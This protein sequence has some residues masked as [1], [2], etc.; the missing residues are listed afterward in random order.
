[1]GKTEKSS[2]IKSWCGY[3]VQ[4]SLVAQL[5]P[6][7]CNP[8]DCSMSD[9]PVQHQLPELAQIHVCW[10]GEATNHLILCQPL[11]LLPS[12]FPSIR[13]F[14]NESVLCFSWPKYRRFS[15]SISPSNEYSG[16]LPLGLTG[17]TSLLS[18]ELSRESSPTP[19]FKRINSL[20]LSFPNSPTQTSIHGHRKNH[21]FE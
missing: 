14:P 11:L 1:M 13:V 8:L 15:F 19:Q 10:F 12:A 3:S 18:K 16:R 21:S 9:L 6:A 7:F 20:A 5:C 4:F 2:N 17:L